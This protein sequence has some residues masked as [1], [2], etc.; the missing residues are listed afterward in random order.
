M[1]NTFVILLVIGASL[2][3]V[4]VLVLSVII[5]RNRFKTRKTHFSRISELELLLTAV[6][7]EN[8]ILKKD[9]EK[10]KY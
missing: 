2:D 6:N 5:M 8:D 9:I 7:E 3:V 4:A 10:L 1:W